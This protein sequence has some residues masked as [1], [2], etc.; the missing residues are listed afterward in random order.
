MPRNHGLV[1]ESMMNTNARMVRPV[2]AGVYYKFNNNRMVTAID[3]KTALVLIDLQKG[4]AK[5]PALTSMADVLKNVSRLVDAFRQNDLPVVVVHVEP[6]QAKWTKARKDDKRPSQSPAPDAT[7]ILEEI[8]T[9][10]GDI[11]IT[12][13][14]WGAFYETPL[15]RELKERNIT[16]IVLAGVST[17]IGVEG[18][19]RGASERGYNI[20]FAQDAMTD[21]VAEA[22][23]RSV[24][25]IFPRMG[26]VD[27][28][29]QII[30]KLGD[31]I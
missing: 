14:T 18:T 27:H 24:K 7:Q 4:I 25:Y 5:N 10:P 28:T 29:A 17:S 26:E 21:T 6:G 11:F 12:K 9:Q 30:Q 3:K 1:F 20:T 16:G 15:D 8:K 22:H 2:L 13:H 31:R 23:E 19:A